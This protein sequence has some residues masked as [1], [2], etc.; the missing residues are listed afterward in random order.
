VLVRC[1]PRGSIHACSLIVGLHLENMAYQTAPTSCE[2]LPPELACRAASDEVKRGHRAYLVLNFFL[3]VNGVEG[4]SKP[5]FT[6]E[7]GMSLSLS[8]VDARVLVYMVLL[9]TSF[10]MAFTHTYPHTNR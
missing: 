4:R 3:N 8:G 2:F 5:D 7:R 10:G 1:L 9:G 6:A